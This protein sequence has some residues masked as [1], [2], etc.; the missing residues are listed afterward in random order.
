MN[1]IKLK[2][3]VDI[4]VVIL[5]LIFMVLILTKQI[6]E[7]EFHYSFSAMLIYSLAILLLKFDRSHH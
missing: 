1:E 3:Q 6:H 5:M 7:T 4:V 2:H